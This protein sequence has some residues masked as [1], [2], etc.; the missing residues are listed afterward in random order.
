MRR[1][2]NKLSSYMWQCCVKG[3]ASVQAVA[4]PAI[5]DRTLRPW[6]PINQTSWPRTPR[7]TSAQTNDS[8]WEFHLRRE[9]S[10][11]YSEPPLWRPRE[12]AHMQLRR[13]ALL[14]RTKVVRCNVTVVRSQ[15]CKITAQL[16]FSYMK[17]DVLAKLKAIADHCV[18]V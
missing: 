5:D 7:K 6:Q 11:T 2:L 14:L 13:R 8:T 10:T 4:R 1:T 12:A 9:P 16:F 15:R 17:G 18:A 3:H